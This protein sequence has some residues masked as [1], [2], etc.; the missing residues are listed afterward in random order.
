MGFNSGFKGLI[1]TWPKHKASITNKQFYS[2][3]T[4]LEYLYKAFFT[5]VCSQDVTVR[6][7]KKHIRR[8]SV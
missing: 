4:C 6:T 2:Y 1:L 5:L 8:N 3:T 7:Y